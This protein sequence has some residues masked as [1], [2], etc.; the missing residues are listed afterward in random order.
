[1]TYFDRTVET[2]AEDQALESA[3]GRLRKDGFVMN[4]GVRRSDGLGVAAGELPGP[5]Y[6]VG[7]GFSGG[8]DEAE[9]QRFATSV[10][11]NLRRHWQVDQ[12]S[13]DVGVEPAAHCP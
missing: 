5:G 2:R 7:L 3:N 6:Q 8:K 4:L 10:I 9:A 12:I 11:E 13:G 1:M